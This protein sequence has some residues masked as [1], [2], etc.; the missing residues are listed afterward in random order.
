MKKEELVTAIKECFKQIEVS[1]A[2]SFFSLSLQKGN[3]SMYQAE[4]YMYFNIQSDSKSKLDAAIEYP[5]GQ[6]YRIDVALFNNTKKQCHFRREDINGIIEFKHY[7]AQ[8]DDSVINNM[9]GGLIYAW[10]KRNTEMVK[11]GNINTG[12]PMAYIQVLFELLKPEANFD[13]YGYKTSDFATIHTYFG[14][15]DWNKVFKKVKSEKSKLISDLENEDVKVL[16][17][18]PDFDYFKIQKSNLNGF[19]INIHYLIYSNYLHETS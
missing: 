13:K 1:R 18:N 5:V 10:E 2:D 3:E 16:F 8:K 6:R 17:D 11:H 9:K 4:M 12:I 19:N 15:N 14:K 7:G